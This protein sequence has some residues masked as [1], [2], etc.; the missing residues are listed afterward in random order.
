MSA[1]NLLLKLILLLLL[2]HHLI[3]IEL[4]NRFTVDFLKKVRRLSACGYLSVV[5]LGNSPKLVWLFLDP[6]VFWWF[7]IVS[8][9]R[10]NFLNLI[11]GVL[12]DKKIWIWFLNRGFFW[13]AI[14]VQL[15]FNLP[16]SWKWLLNL[17][18]SLIFVAGVKLMNQMSKGFTHLLDFLASYVVSWKASFLIK[19]KC[20]KTQFSTWMLVQ[21]FWMENFLYVLISWE[22]T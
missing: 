13:S 9:D 4:F 5:A 21:R 10:N 8:E 7:K 14:K 11:V 12:I 1:R 6:E 2:H 3:L 20:V 18:Q 19:H 16:S 15:K 22:K 17:R